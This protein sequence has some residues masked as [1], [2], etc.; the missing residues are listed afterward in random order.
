M[1]YI[2]TFFGEESNFF[3]MSVDGRYLSAHFPKG[4]PHEDKMR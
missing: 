1:Q 3:V 2:Y 4:V